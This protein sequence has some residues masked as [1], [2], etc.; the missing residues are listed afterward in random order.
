MSGYFLNIYLVVLVFIDDSG[1][2]Q[3]SCDDCLEILCLSTSRKILLLFVPLFVYINVTHGLL[4]HSMV[5]CI[6]SW[7]TFPTAFFFF[8]TLLC[9]FSSLSSLFGVSHSRIVLYTLCSRPNRRRFCKWP[10]FWLLN[11]AH[12]NQDMSANNA[13]CDW[14][15]IVSKL[16]ID[17]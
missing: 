9:H 4:F 14:G 6:L 1:L 15:V 17:I 2:I 11:V 12:R 7:D 13:H 5:Y 8:L 16:H 10:Y 3:L